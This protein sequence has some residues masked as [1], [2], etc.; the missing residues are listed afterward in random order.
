MAKRP[1]HLADWRSIAD[2][3]E[4]YQAYLCSREWA[5]KREAIRE[6]AGGK[7]ERCRTLPMDAV[8]H[9]TYARKYNED[10]ADL[11]AICSACHEF[12][13]GKSDVDP[14]CYH[15]GLLRACYRSSR[16]PCPAMVIWCQSNT[17]DDIQALLFYLDM[18]RETPLSF[19][20]ARFARVRT[21]N[22][23]QDLLGF[24]VPTRCNRIAME[25]TYSPSWYIEACRI[26]GLDGE[27]RD[28]ERRK[29]EE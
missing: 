8:H 4:K 27:L 22:A 5:E 21:E 26:F 17:S 2:D 10:L 3:K 19:E 7:C 16:R 20:G 9:L 28:E 24:W 13:H 6:R 14:A 29:E 23:I 11:Q 18:V 15:A 12:T 25:L 1:S